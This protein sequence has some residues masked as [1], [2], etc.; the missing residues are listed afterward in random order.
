MGIGELAEGPLHAAL[1]RELAG[2]HDAFEVPLGRWVIDLV[3]ADGEL[4]EIQTGGFSPLG[5]KLDGLL[6]SHRMRIVHP[7]PARRWVIR[8]GP[9]GAM[10]SRR[11]SPRPARPVDLFHQLVAF[12]TLVGHPNLV[13]EVL[14]VEEDHIRAAAPVRTGRRRRDP[15]QRHLVAVLDR[16]EL[17]Q[18]ADLLGLLPSALPEGDFTTAQLATATRTTTML[19]QRIVFCLRHAA[20]L[21]PAGKLA[22]APLHRAVGP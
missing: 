3:R 19:A 9:D 13:V 8:T 22:H 2:P 7:L 20:L 18:P 11:R 4:V 14:L 6:D 5:P 21:E 10:L 15:G 1:K 12:P 16:V 17:R